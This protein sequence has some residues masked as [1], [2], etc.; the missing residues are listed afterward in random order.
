[1]SDEEEERRKR[2]A[3][4]FWKDRR[5]KG[6]TLY[7]AELLMRQR[8]YFAAMMVNEGDA[9]VMLSGYSRAYPSVLKPLLE[10]IGKAPGVSRV[11]A[12]NLMNTSRGP[13]FISDTAVNVDPSAKELAKIAQ[14]TANTVNLFGL[15]PVIAMLSYSNFGSSRN[16]RATKVK[17]AVAYLHRFYPD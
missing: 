10:L 9:D 16:E 1:K 5:R 8:N 7:D 15:E 6:V 11:A 17:E 2:Y 3:Q 12:T 14:L 13:I 4:V